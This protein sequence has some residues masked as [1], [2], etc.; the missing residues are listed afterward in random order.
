MIL[1]GLFV[2]SAY[3]QHPPSDK[4]WE[5]V[6][7]DNFNTFNTNRWMAVDHFDHYGELQLYR[8]Q[9][10][11][12]SNGKLVL[13]TKEEDYCCPPKYVNPSNCSRQDTSGKCYQY[14]SGYVKS[15]V[16]YRYGYFEIYAKLPGGDGFWPAFWLHGNGEDPITNECY[17]NE[18]DVVEIFPCRQESIDTGLTYDVDCVNSGK[19]PWVVQVPCNFPYTYHWYGVEWDKDKITFYVDRKAVRQE[20]NNMKGIGIQYPMNIKINTALHSPIHECPVT[21]S[22]IFPNY[23]YVDTANVYRLKCDKNTSVTEI[24]NYDTF[25]YAVK[26]SITL[27]G[28]S[29]LT[30]G[31]DV[32]LR[33]TDFIELKNGFEVPLGAELYLD[34]NPCDFVRTVEQE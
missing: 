32:S 31:Q 9:N 28:V 16:R 7:Q 15:K 3:S 8:S 22:S 4:N 27:S 2:V 25:N 17:Y 19:P 20:I 26:K 30:S 29:S 6:F 23:M 11:Y 18:I 34:I 14:T 33:A 21:G 24:S 13:E 10:V 5:T 1:A 12:L